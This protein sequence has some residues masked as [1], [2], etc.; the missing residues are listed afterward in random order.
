MGSMQGF[1]VLLTNVSVQL[2]YSSQNPVLWGFM[3]DSE[4]IMIQQIVSLVTGNKLNFHPSPFLGSKAKSYSLLNISSL[5]L[6]DIQESSVTK[7][8]LKKKKTNIYPALEISKDF[9]SCLPGNR[10]KTKYTFHSI[11][12]SQI[13]SPHSCLKPLLT[14]D[15]VI[16]CPTHFTASQSTQDEIQFLPR[17]T[18][19]E[20]DPSLPFFQNTSSF[21]SEHRICQFTENVRCFSMLSS[22]AWVPT[23]SLCSDDSYLAST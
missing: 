7:Q 1:Q 8:L 23:P 22:L 5:Y 13:H 14:Q 12:P 4:Y 11:T 20:H 10:R 19:T 2:H 9:R 21:P 18:R 15:H 16:S 6:K 17:P 3:K